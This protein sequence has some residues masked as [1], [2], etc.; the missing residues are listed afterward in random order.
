[1]RRVLCTH[2]LM[3][4]IACF[5]FGQ[6]LKKEV[7]SSSVVAKNPLTDAIVAKEKQVTD[8]LMN[9]DSGVLDDLL[10]NEGFLHGS[11]GRTSIPD[12][13]KEALSP[14]FNLKDITMEEPHVLT[15]DKDAAVLSYKSTRTHESQ[16]KT[17]KYTV[18]ASSIWVKRNGEWKT[19]F[20]QETPASSQ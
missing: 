17:E 1:M 3:M 5:T 12:F 7:K 18:F 19:V 11:E 6:T 9:K 4:L 10:L 20:H 8:A 15:L 13:K 16:G 14:N 2:L